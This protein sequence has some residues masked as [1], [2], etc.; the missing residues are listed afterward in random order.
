MKGKTVLYIGKTETS[1]IFSDVTKKTSTFLRAVS[2]KNLTSKDISN[3]VLDSKNDYF[4]VIVNLDEIPNAVNGDIEFIEDII[5]EDRT[6]ICVMCPGYSRE[7][8][9]VKKCLNYGVQFF[10]LF[11]NDKWNAAVYER[12]INP[13]IISNLKDVYSDELSGV[14]TATQNV[15]NEQISKSE[16]KAPIEPSEPTSSADTSISL[17]IGGCKERIGVTLIATYLTKTLNTMGY[18]ACYVDC[19]KNNEYMSLFFQVYSQK[20]ALDKEHHKLFYEGIDFFANITP[21]VLSYI[22]GS[23]YDYVVYDFGC[24]Y[25]NQSKIK[26]FLTGDVKFLISGFRCDEFRNYTSLM[27]SLSEEERSKITSIFHLV[28]KNDKKPLEE[29]IQGKYKTDIKFLEFISD[30]YSVNNNSTRIA[31]NV[32]NIKEK[33]NE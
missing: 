22:S 4:A 31:K 1:G 14:D 23:G 13:N 20:G 7:S 3:L 17:Y 24:L 33:S 6:R 5:G 15:Q 16:G 27:D 28:K 12:L 10:M 19:T 8:E 18:K 9:K 32:F 25:N 26:T 2:G 21:A 29:Y 30:E 11:P